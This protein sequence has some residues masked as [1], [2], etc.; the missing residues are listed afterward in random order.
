M[1]SERV[2]CIRLLLLLLMMLLMLMTEEGWR[3]GVHVSFTVICL[4]CESAEE[5]F[6]SRPAR[7][8]L[9]LRT[10]SSPAPGGRH[11]GVTC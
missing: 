3:R 7:S 11:K 8:A 5:G 10:Q 1:L 2:G 9:G 6:A 4:N